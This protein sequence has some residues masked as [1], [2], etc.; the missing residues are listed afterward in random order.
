[1]A[2]CRKS[3]QKSI[4]VSE[5]GVELARFENANLCITTHPLSC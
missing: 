3:E 1:M 4:L 5:V 2:F